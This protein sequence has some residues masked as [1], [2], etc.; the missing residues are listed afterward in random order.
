MHFRKP[1]RPRYTRPSPFCR[2]GVSRSGRHTTY[3]VNDESVWTIQHVQ[4]RSPD[5]FLFLSRIFLENLHPRL[6]SLKWIQGVRWRSTLPINTMHG[7]E[8]QPATYHR[9]SSECIGWFDLSICGPEDSWRSSHTAC[10]ALWCLKS[11]PVFPAKHCRWRRWNCSP[12]V[13][14]YGFCGYHG[15][16]MKS[17]RKSGWN[18]QLLKRW[19]LTVSMPASWLADHE[20]YSLAAAANWWQTKH[21]KKCIFQLTLQKY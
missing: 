1:Q 4:E 15:T 17:P 6:V 9:S 13:S 12:P 3:H 14:T 2:N 21:L 11:T 8:Y 18:S 19:L 16:W 7:C 5:S 10:V 20:S